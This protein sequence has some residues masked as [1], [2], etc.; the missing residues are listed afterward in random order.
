[1]L[2]E[3][4]SAWYSV[5]GKS[6]PGKPVP[7]GQR[8]QKR[9]V[10]EKDEKYWEKRKKN[11]ESA[12]KSRDKSKQLDQQIKNRCLELEYENCLLRREIAIMKTR[13]RVPPGEEFL[14]DRDRE[15]C[16]KEVPEIFHNAIHNRQ[17]PSTKANIIAQNFTVD[18][19][20]H[21]ITPDTTTSPAPISENN[22]ID[23]KRSLDD[24][25]LEQTPVRPQEYLWNRLSDVGATSSPIGFYRPMEE[26][27]N[28]CPTDLS[29]NK[30]NSNTELDNA[31]S[32][33]NVFHLK[34]H[35]GIK[36]TN[37]CASYPVTISQT[38]NA[39]QDNSKSMKVSKG[40]KDTSDEVVTVLDLT[41]DDDDKDCDEDLNLK[42]K[43]LADQIVAM[44]TLVNLKTGVKQE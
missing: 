34:S 18:S 10:Q 14:T 42:L 22:T 4:S 28:S 38:V 32:D 30:R 37:N 17:S 21:Q 8:G 1:M 35:A 24:Q 19:P 25:M 39:V 2:A 7:R 33:R 40:R 44:Q 36:P 41:C 16:A 43:N 3:A 13:Y 23:G 11:N 29:I 26:D 27:S 5:E 9:G 12:K 6:S 20:Q 31:E 15:D